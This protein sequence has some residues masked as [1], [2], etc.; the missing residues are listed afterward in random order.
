VSPYLEI[1][2]TPR[3]A[4]LAAAWLVSRLPAG[5]NGL[6]ILL[7]LRATTGSYATAGAVAGAAALGTGLGAPLL[8]RLVDRHGRVVVLPAAI[9]NALALL[10]LVAL[11]RA[12]APTPVLL[13]VGLSVGLSSP[14]T[15]AMLRVLWPSL[16]HGRPHL[17]RTAFALDSVFIEA[18]FVSGPLLTGLLVA[19]ASAEVALL[20]SAA[21]TLGGSIAFVARLPADAARPQTQDSGLGPLG[22]LRSPGIR[23][24]AL[25]SLPVG[26]AFGA[27]EVAL[28]A[29][30]E[31]E[32]AR[33]LAGVLVA[34][35]S[36]GSLAG[37]LVFGAR[38]RR[39][40]LA[41]LHLRIALVLPLLFLPLLVAPSVA[42]MAV[43]VLPAGAFIAPLIATR[44]E[45]A[46][47]AAPPGARTEAL[48][49]PLTALLSGIA[50]GAGVA[51]ALVDAASWEAPVVAAAL[52]A[53][54]GAAVVAGRRTTLAPGPVA[55]PG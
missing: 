37:G 35:W 9:V 41:A 3:V 43:L 50:L 44:N 10:G 28:P 48:T 27:V 33:E 55:Q 11:G 47:E 26:F 12:G 21:A 54:I 39:A 42:L 19:V 34:V 1:L 17:V 51:G 4:P 16:L 36:L 24:L 7:F 49:W 32:G 22:A 15:A 23:T 40:A 45:L 29:F 38:P 30:A 31:E 8:G 6:A 25:A 14:P 20:V 5:I 13:A 18:V 2:R 52:A 46:A 53:L